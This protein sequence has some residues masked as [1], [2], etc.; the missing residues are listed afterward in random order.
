MARITLP[1]WLRAAVPIIDQ[2]GHHRA[3]W[4]GRHISAGLAIAAVA[5]PIGVAYSAIAGLPPA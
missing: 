4:L 3:E 5:L 2:M 1:T